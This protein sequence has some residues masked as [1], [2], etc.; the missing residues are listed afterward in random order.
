[1]VKPT[2]VLLAD[3]TTVILEQTMLCKISSV[4][5]Y[6]DQYFT[7]VLVFI[8]WVIACL[9]AWWQYTQSKS[10]STIS[11]H[12]EWVREFREKL[13]NLETQSLDFWLKST[14][15]RENLLHFNSAKRE[16]KELTT[17]ARELQKASKVDYPNRDFIRL[18]R[19]LTSDRML[20]S[21][22]L[23]TN[24]DKIH[25]IISVMGKLRSLYV[26]KS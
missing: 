10:N 5:C 7:W 20:Q 17:I 14:T 24:D 2:L 21:K 18:R 9:I 26:R 3:D 25:E 19:A 11:C 23:A 15:D 13:S 4:L 8:G 12:N 1:M 22:P 6:E 16:I